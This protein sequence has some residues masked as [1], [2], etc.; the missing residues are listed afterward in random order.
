MEFGQKP[1]S[2]RRLAGLVGVVIFHALLIWGLVSGLA[3][4]AIELLPPPIETKII[5]E[6]K[7]PDEPPPP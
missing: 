3:R 1:N 2:S 4:K 6:V 5:E 7:P